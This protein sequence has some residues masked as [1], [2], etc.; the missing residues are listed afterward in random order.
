LIGT[1]SEETPL[2]GVIDDEI[3]LTTDERT[4]LEEGSIPLMGILF[5]YLV[6]FKRCSEQF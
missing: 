2:Y 6:C 1:P 4:I 5:L 3:I